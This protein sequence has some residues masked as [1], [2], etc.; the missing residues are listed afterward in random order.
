MN[1]AVAG[2]RGATDSVAVAQPKKIA[3]L[4]SLLLDVVAAEVVDALRAWGIRSIL[5]KGA[6]TAGWLYDDR[7][8]TYLDV[9]LLVD[10]HLLTDAGRVLAELGFE[11]ESDE[12]RGWAMAPHAENW[13]RARDAVF[14]DLHWQILGIGADP[15]RAWEVLSPATERMPLGDT[16]VE[17]L[18]IP[19]RT[20]HLALHAAQHGVR[21]DQSRDDLLRGITRLPEDSWQAAASLAETLGA[22]EPMAV[23]LRLVPEGARLA[24]RLGLPTEVSTRWALLART[25]PR[26]GQRLY[27]IGAASGARAKAQR[28]AAGLVPPPSHI[29]RLFPWARGRRWRLV[30]AYAVRLVR[31]LRDMPGAVRAI[32]R[33]RLDARRSRHGR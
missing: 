5:L 15:V 17:A 9:D 22:V 7:E 30:L 8:R 19:A 31:G 2:R 1:R 24:D 18:G 32:W 21:L 13:F 27:E 23:G 28:L 20:L 12:R 25:P 11:Q 14:V 3:A 26:G 29:R 10:P 33:A 6:V 16:T 4:R